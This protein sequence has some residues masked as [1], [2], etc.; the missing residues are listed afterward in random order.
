VSKQSEG[1]QQARWRRRQL[2]TCALIANNYGT[3]GQSREGDEASV[4]DEASV[5][6]TQVPRA[7][8]QG[9]GSTHVAAAALVHRCTM[10]KQ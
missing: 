10:S 6:G 5:Y 8:S 1:G 4:T 2:C 7:N 3:S 9:T